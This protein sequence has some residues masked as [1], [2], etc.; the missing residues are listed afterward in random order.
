MGEGKSVPLCNLQFQLFS[1]DS[2]EFSDCLPYLKIDKLIVG[3][4][5]DQFSQFFSS[6]QI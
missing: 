1:R 2:S 5:V 6:D 3:E 4:H